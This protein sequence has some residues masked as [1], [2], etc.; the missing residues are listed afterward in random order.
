MTAP[1]GRAELAIVITAFLWGSTFTVVKEALHDISTFLFLALRFCV[2]SLLL[3]AV[4]RGR[5]SGKGDGRLFRQAG[6]VTGSLL[7]LG[8]ALQTEGLHLTTA[9]KSAFLTGLYIVL[10]PFFSSLVS[11]TRPRA[12]EVGGAIAGC[13]GTALLSAQGSVWNLGVGEWLTIGCAAAFAAHMVAVEHY[14][15]RM[16]YELLA[17]LQV[18]AVGAWSLVALPWLETPRVVWSGRVWFALTLTAV[19]AT[20][21][22]FALYTW[23]QRHTSA[24]RAA[25]LFSLEPVFAGLVAWVAAGEVWTL[26]MLGGATLILGGILMVELKPGLAAQ[27]P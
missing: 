17:V 13:A 2:G 21:V 5:F 8:Y 20:A 9:S 15:R 1:R 22:S 12:V 19:F 3:A 16:S 14:S 6:L 18:A 4:Y 23:A 11:K 25:L 26:R 27:H 7:F 24:T 10:V